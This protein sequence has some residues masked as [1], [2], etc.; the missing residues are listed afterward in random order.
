MKI[1]KFKT[2]QILIIIFFINLLMFC[3]FYSNAMVFS[4]FSREVYIPMAMNNGN[5]MYKDI[6]N[7]YAPL[8]YTINAFL[9]SLFGE[10]LKTFYFAG[11]INSTLILFGLFFILKLFMRSNYIHILSVL[12][13]IISANIYAVSQT[14]YISPYSYSIVY[15]LNSFIWALA[16]I[17][18]FFKNNNKIFLYSAFFLA[19]VS[20]SCKYEFIPV[21][22]V[23]FTVLIYKKAGL[24][25]NLFCVLF[26][27]SV[28]ALL[29]FNLLLKGVSFNLLKE[30]ITYMLLLTKAKS[31]NTLYTYLGFMPS[32]SSL[33]V[34]AEYFFK[35]LLFVSFIIALSA[36]NLKYST[37]IKKGF[38]VFEAVFVICVFYLLIKVFTQGNAFYFNW[39]GIFSLILFLFFSIKLLKK[40]K[41]K[42]IKIEDKL[43]LILFSSAVLCSYKCIFNISFN[44]YGTYYFPLLFICCF[45]YFYI[46]K[47]KGLKKNK[48]KYT[49][50]IISAALICTTGALYFFSN[51][52][53]AK[54]VYGFCRV[55]T[56]RGTLSPGIEQIEA[57]NKTVNYIK[58]NTNKDDTVLVL[59][60]GAIINF[61]SERKSHNKYYYLIPPNIEIFGEDKIVKDLEKDLPDYIVIQPMSYNNFK[62]TFFCESFGRE[63]CALIP[64]Y[65]ERPLVFGEDFWLA[66]YKKRN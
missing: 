8:G 4:D 23:L 45:L 52:E 62:E 20:I 38:L 58:T 57:V 18:Y 22:F 15:A 42:S 47:L 17:L 64:K 6:F 59:P 3:I 5:V 54:L 46:Y 29:I 65:Y 2:Y 9:I 27:C 28:P 7:V 13:L 55:N 50:Y 51:F 56:E 61:L 25:T 33:K 44:S 12:F 66:V 32:L 41:E 10:N 60:E 63:I 39:I 43:F 48:Y 11:F 21:I 24:K 14:N 19:G 37:K 31:V 49:A 16:G 36:T 26:L 53:R 35:M 1:S 30:T 40:Y 34:L